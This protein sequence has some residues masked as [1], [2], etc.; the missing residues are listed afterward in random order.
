MATT[1]AM[2]TFS[3]GVSG[4]SLLLQGMGGGEQAFTMAKSGK[5][6]GLR[7]FNFEDRSPG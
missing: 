2:L 5:W 4:V 3:V 6:L 1:A 7:E